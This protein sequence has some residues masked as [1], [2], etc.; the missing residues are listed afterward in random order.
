MSHPDPPKTMPDHRP[1]LSPLPTSYTA[2]SCL[3]CRQHAPF[4]ARS[5]MTTPTVTHTS[6]PQPSQKNVATN[7]VTCIRTH[8]H[9][10]VSSTQRS[11]LTSSPHRTRQREPPRHQRCLCCQR[12]NT[13]L[14][15]RKL[16]PTTPPSIRHSCQSPF[17]ALSR[18]PS[19]AS[20]L[21]SSVSSYIII[22]LSH[23]TQL[24]HVTPAVYN[25]YFEYLYSILE[26]PLRIILSSL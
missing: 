15:P 12:L 8:V 17:H 13:L 1:R 25:P 20:P 6:P 16:S 21:L 7:G 11:H 4:T 26:S 2:P 3:Q 5:P 10:D 19:P 22:T 18:P 23:A 9:W 14:C 24:S